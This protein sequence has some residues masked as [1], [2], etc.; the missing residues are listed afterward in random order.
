VLKKLER[1]LE[2]K[3]GRAEKGKPSPH[4]EVAPSQLDTLD[5]IVRTL[6]GLRGMAKTEACASV[7]HFIEMALVEA[8]E[9]LTRIAKEEAQRKNN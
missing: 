3:D 4:I 6:V 9:T 1:E 5:Y 8:S 2:M 7:K